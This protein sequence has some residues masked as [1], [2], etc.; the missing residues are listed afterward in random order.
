MVYFNNKIKSWYSL[1]TWASFTLITSVFVSI[2][3]F[4]HQNNSTALRGVHL[5]G[6]HPAEYLVELI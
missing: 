2:K 1:I 3:Q 5:L 6:Q 4:C